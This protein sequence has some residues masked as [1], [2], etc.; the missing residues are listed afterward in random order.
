M[1]RSSGLFRTAST[2]HRQNKEGNAKNTPSFFVDRVS[3]SRRL[4]CGILYID[5]LR[6][7]PP[8]ARFL[9]ARTRA[10]Q[11]LF[12]FCL[13]FFTLLPYHAVDY[14]V[15]G[16]G[17]SQ[18][19][20][21][22]FT[23]IFTSPFTRIGNLGS[24]FMP[25]EKQERSHCAFSFASEAK[26]EGRRAKVFTPIALCTNELRPAGEE[27][28]AKNEN[29]LTRARGLA[30]DARAPAAQSG[31]EKIS[32]CRLTL[33]A[34]LLGKSIPKYAHQLIKTCLTRGISEIISDLCSVV[35]FIVLCLIRF[36]TTNIK[37]LWSFH[38][39]WGQY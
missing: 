16:E 21:F 25:V 20:P 37:E 28:K 5:C 11:L 3:F 29:R 23:R 38:A 39:F 13:H 15:R 32:T 30:L 19:G 8:F 18:K 35:G 12:V 36:F 27:V 22:P 26:R 1:Q 9:V 17:F 24:A 4:E 7:V 33:Q 34:L 6:N 14:C 31:N 10:H 2:R